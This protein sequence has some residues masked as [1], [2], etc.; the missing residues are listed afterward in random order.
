MK[1]ADTT[2]APDFS[3]TVDTVNETQSFMDEMTRESV[4]PMELIDV[5]CFKTENWKKNNL[6]KAENERGKRLYA[7][8]HQNPTLYRNLYEFLLVAFATVKERAKVMCQ[9][10]RW[11]MEFHDED[12]MEVLKCLRL[13]IGDCNLLLQVLT[14]LKPVSSPEGCLQKANEKFIPLWNSCRK[15]RQK[16]PDRCMEKSYYI[17]KLVSHSVKPFLSAALL[18]FE[19]LKNLWFAYLISSTLDDMSKGNVFDENVRFETFTISLFIASLVLTYVICCLISVFYS[20]TIVELYTCKHSTPQVKRIVA[21]LAALFSPLVPAFLLANHAHYREQSYTLTRE[22]QCDIMPSDNQTDGRKE[23]RLVTTFKLIQFN[24]FRS[25]IHTRLYSF[26]RVVH[27]VIES[28]FCITTLLLILIVTG[29]PD[30]SVKLLDGVSAKIG[31]FLPGTLNDD[32]LFGLNIARDLIFMGSCLFSCVMILTALS[33]YVYHSKGQN[34]TVKGQVCLSLY[35]LFMI[36]S[37]LT[38]FVALFSTSEAREGEELPITL[39][40]AAFIAI[41]LISV[42]FVIIWIYKWKYVPEFRMSNVVEQFVHVL[43]NTLLVVPFSTYDIQA[44]KYRKEP[45]P[46]NILLNSLSD[47]IS[48]TLSVVQLSNKKCIHETKNLQR[49][50]RY[51]RNTLR[52]ASA[53]NEFD[54]DV[55]DLTTAPLIVR[56]GRLHERIEKMWWENPN[57]YLDQEQVRKRLPEFA[58]QEIYVDKTFEFLEANGFINKRLYNPRQTKS[59]YFWLLLVH[60]VINLIALIAEI[61]NGGRTTQAGLYY[62]WD[63]RL[64]TFFMGLVFLLLYYKQY[65]VMKDLVTLPLCSCGYAFVKF[66]P[67]LFCAKKEQAMQAIPDDDELKR[68]L[69]PSLKAR[70]FATQTSDLQGDTNDDLVDAIVAESKSKEEAEQDVEA[71]TIVVENGTTK[72]TE[73]SSITTRDVAC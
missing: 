30:R 22:L 42:H 15:L 28:V 21:V 73:N 54:A 72:E 27:A 58:G 47:E 71:I 67:I 4:L 26:Y 29:R 45:P 37:R 17:V 46:S 14:T 35:F 60:L 50:R 33:R 68:S 10:E 69:N 65:H 23:D 5:L 8:V 40:A 44:K 25:M 59:E 63:V 24:N 56:L 53:Y 38:L 61:V 34:M 48:L 64:G 3:I 43:V 7:K 11:E 49:E 55:I 1:N 2:D 16:M 20:N 41:P 39:L 6:Y 52:S 31:E 9:L 51:H 57:E 19:W 70:T 66:C 12:R 36:A 32:S 18:Y 13:H 62:S